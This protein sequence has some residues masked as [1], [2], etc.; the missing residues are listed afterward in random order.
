MADLSKYQTNY[1]SATPEEKAK[2]LAL[3]EAYIPE[4][5]GFVFSQSSNSKKSAPLEEK[6]EK[7]E[8]ANNTQES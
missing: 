4:S 5:I 1:S 2:Y 6:E 3:Q 7:T 8:Q